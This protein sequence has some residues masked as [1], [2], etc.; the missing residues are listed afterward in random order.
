MAAPSCGGVPRPSPMA[1]EG[2]LLRKAVLSPRERRARVER[3]QDSL[4]P[5]EAQV[6]WRYLNGQS[7]EEIALGL[8]LKRDSIKSY[9]SAIRKKYRAQG[10]VL[11]VKRG[12]GR[13]TLWAMK[14]PR[15]P[16]GKGKGVAA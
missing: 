14:S 12:S 7:Y 15:R 5:C 3:L 10:L 13:K 1:T 8:R 2:A 11:P 9:M 6:L 4:A 16:K